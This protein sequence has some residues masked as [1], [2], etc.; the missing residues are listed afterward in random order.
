[1]LGSFHG[2]QEDAIGF[3][4]YSPRFQL[5]D[6][7]FFKGGGDVMWGGSTARGAPKVMQESKEAFGCS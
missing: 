5:E 3:D 6:E 4:D 7:L 1:L 2:I